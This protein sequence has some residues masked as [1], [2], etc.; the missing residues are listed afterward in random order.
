M[1]CFVHYCFSQHTTEPFH[2]S[3]LVPRP[4]LWTCWVVT[5]IYLCNFLSKDTRYNNSFDDG[6][7]FSRYDF[8]VMGDNPNSGDSDDSA[9]AT[10]RASSPLTA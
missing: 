3:N 9:T 6:N 5:G 1:T 8:W 7:N 10:G 2:E 4:P